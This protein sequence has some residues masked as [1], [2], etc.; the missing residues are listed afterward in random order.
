MPSNCLVC[1][2]GGISAPRLQNTS[3]P[4]IPEI[5]RSYKDFY[6]YQPDNTPEWYGFGGRANWGIATAAA[7]VENLSGQTRVTTTG[8][9]IK[10][11]RPNANGN[12]FIKNA[13]TKTTA[14][15]KI[16]KGVGRVS[17]G[18]GFAM[19]IRG[20]QIYNNDPSSLN[21]VH[22]N[23]MLLNTGM[24]LLG[25]EGG[26]YGAI[27]STLYFGIDNYYPGGWVGASETAARTEAYE[28]QMTGHPLFSN[29]ALKF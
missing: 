16:G 13:Y 29:S 12:V 2:G 14:I 3:T 17:L 9:S 28:Q 26:V 6:P 5:R 1:N 10:L 4:N 19:D 23:K 20:V 22:P 11:Y 7:S 27:I 8:S 24:G 15:S 21:A 25:T 18:I